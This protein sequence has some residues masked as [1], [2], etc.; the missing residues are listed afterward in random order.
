MNAKGKRILLIA[1]GALLVAAVL[2]VPFSAVTYE[3]GGTRE[4]AA[5]TYKVV[6]WKRLEAEHDAEGKI[7]AINQ[8]KNTTVYFFPDN[9]K[10]IDELWDIEQAH[11][12]N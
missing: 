11:R 9:L 2:F 12:S 7:A 3:D 6:V 4:Y 1:L 5:L 10:S 8:Y